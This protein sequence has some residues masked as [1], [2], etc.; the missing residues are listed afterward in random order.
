MTAIDFPNSPSVG[1][2]HIV[3]SRVW[4]WTGTTWDAV[5]SA[6]GILSTLYSYTHNQVSTSSTWTV[7]HNL[8]YNPAINIRDNSGQIIEGQITYNNVNTLTLDFSIAISGT[9]YLS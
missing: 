3:G 9:A 6:A 1:Q 7:N 8:G 2:Q 4:E 5:T